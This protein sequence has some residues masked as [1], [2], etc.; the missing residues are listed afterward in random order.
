MV[1]ASGLNLPNIVCKFKNAYF[2]LHLYEIWNPICVVENG[3]NRKRKQGQVFQSVLYVNCV[4][5]TE[6]D[7]KIL[8]VLTNIFKKVTLDNIFTWVLSIVI[9]D[10]L[11]L[12]MCV[13]QCGRKILQN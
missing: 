7:L 8:R 11:S 9:T 3:K 5:M 6:K 12:D 2:G 10:Y 1:K 4:K 13:L